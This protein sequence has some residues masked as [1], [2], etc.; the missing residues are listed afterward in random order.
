M[1]DLLTNQSIS[2]AVAAVM[3][4]LMNL[5]GGQIS[6]GLTPGQQ[7]ALRS[8]YVRWITILA[9]FYV[10][11]RD[12]W[13]SLGLSVVTIFTLEYLLNE[14]SRYY[15]FRRQRHD[16]KIYAMGTGALTMWN[17]L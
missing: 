16:G 8:P 9:V 15:L 5:T 1:H 11:T 7:R 12:I 17:H 3:M 10:G 2:T 14:S 13:V 6:A 4:L